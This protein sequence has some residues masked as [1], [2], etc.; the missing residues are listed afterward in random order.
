MITDMAYV[1]SLVPRRKNDANKGDFG[2]VL[3]IAGSSGMMGAAVLAAKAALRT[4]SGT[5]TL[6]VPDTLKND[7]NSI[8][9]E[10]TVIGFSELNENFKRFDVIAVGPGLGKGPKISKMIKDI[11]TSKS[12]DAPLVLD[13]DGLNAI[14]DKR[15]LKGSKKE[16]VITPHPGEFSRLTGMGV[17]EIQRDRNGT[18]GR[19]ASKNKLTVLLKGANTV[20]A[21]KDGKI[22]INPTGNP[23]MATGG[24][25]DVLTG[26]IASLIGQGIPPFD[27]AAAGAYIHGM[28]GNLAVSIKGEHGMIASDIIDSIPYTMNMLI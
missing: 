22:L 28:A 9:L 25:G 26:I 8:S 5:V 7:I 23:G 24:S 11:I 18:A 10:A 14:T 3:V 1:S 4:G 19:F 2:K 6:C 27:A 16:I 17:Q 13:A 12:S 15:I 21:G 20:I